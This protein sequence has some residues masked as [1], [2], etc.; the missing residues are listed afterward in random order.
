MRTRYN[1]DANDIVNSF[2]R[3]INSKEKLKEPNS[4]IATI[5]KANKL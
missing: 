2:D 1:K 3:Y 5:L 4:I